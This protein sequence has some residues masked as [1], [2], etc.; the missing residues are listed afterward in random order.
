MAAATPYTAICL[1]VSL[2]G[3]DGFET[4][5]RLR[6]DGIATPII[7]L[8]ARDAVDDRIAGLNAGADDY[9]VKP[10]AFGELLARLHA[11]ARRPPAAPV[12]VLVVG[13]LTLDP[14]THR[15]RRG[16]ARARPL[17]QGAADPRGV[18]APP[19]RGPDAPAA[20][21]G[22]V[23]LGLREPLERH[24]RLRP[25]AARED[26]PAV[27]RRT[28]SRPCAAPGTGCAP[29]EPARLPRAVTP[30]A[31]P[32]PPAAPP[33]G[34]LATVALARR[35][36]ARSRRRAR[37][38]ARC[39]SPP[40]DA[41]A[42]L[43]RSNARGRNSSGKPGAASRTT[44]RDRAVG[45]TRRAQL[46]RARA[47]AQ[48]VD[49]EVVERLRDA[50]RVGARRRRR[51]RRRRGCRSRAPPSRR[52]PVARR[53]SP[54]AG[55]GRRA[56][57]AA[58]A[59]RPGRRARGRAAS[60][61]RRDSRSLSPSASSSAARS[62]SGRRR[63]RRAGA[64]SSRVRRMLIGVRSSW[65]ASPTMRRSRSSAPLRRSSRSLRVVARRSS[66]SPVPGSGRR[67]RPCDP[68]IAAA[69][70]RMRS[71]GRSAAPATW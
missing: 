65:L 39:R 25:I 23:G 34:R 11:L 64:T 36:R 40:C 22:R 14:A 10:F 51:R 53:R 55:P 38:P 8:T 27:R 24:R 58:A 71:T 9:L 68:P 15:V 45:C 16:G 50:V 3:I 4:C 59:A 61:A 37:G 13:D 31:A 28:R 33:S 18:H 47:V 63:R 12:P 5:R 1:D 7:M 66:S 20:A 57:R 43:K 2:P 30:P 17:G 41:S 19:R 52:P 67:S 48:R 35:G 21:R 42:W 26:R 62:C 44:R 54:R 29:R 46:D 49:D 69:F 32:A 60:S 70:A 6:A 56:A